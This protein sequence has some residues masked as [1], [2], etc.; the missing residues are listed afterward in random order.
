MCTH[1]VCTPAP[2][3]NAPLLLSLPLTGSHINM[4]THSHFQLFLISVSLPVSATQTQSGTTLTHKYLQ[5]PVSSP[6]GA[7]MCCW[8][9]GADV[10]DEDSPHHLSTAHSSAH[11]SASHDADT[12]GLA[13]CSSQPHT[14]TQ[15]RIAGT[16]TH[17][18]ELILLTVR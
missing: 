9:V 10:L 17:V 16:S 8:A 3:A 15:S 11:A 7:I 4:Q 13:W 14:K 2:A 18:V 1:S 5:Y 12:Q 6:K